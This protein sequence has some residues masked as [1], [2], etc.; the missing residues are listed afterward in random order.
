MCSGCSSAS[1][2]HLQ[3]GPPHMFS[4]TLPSSSSSSESISSSHA[5]SLAHGHTQIHEESG[6]YVGLTGL[7][8][9]FRM[10]LAL[11]EALPLRSEGYRRT[12][13][14]QTFHAPISTYSRLRSIIW[15]APLLIPFPVAAKYARHSAA[16]PQI[17]GVSGLAVGAVLTSG[18]NR[19]GLRLRSR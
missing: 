14:Q 6:V 5:L 2:S 7:A 12:E 8:L 13:D 17:R 18:I 10:R 15:S 16:V 19:G 3:S 11:S 9:G 4:S 1:L